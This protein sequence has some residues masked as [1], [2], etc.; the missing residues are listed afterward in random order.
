VT[1]L[2]ATV[3]EDDEDGF[4]AVEKARITDN[5]FDC[6]GFFPD[7]RSEAQLPA[8]VLKMREFP[9]PEGEL[10]AIKARYAAMSETDAAFAMLC[11]LGLMEDYDSLGEYSD[12][13]ADDAM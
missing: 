4:N 1:A 6:H 8:A 11:D 9:K 2:T 5:C 13:F 3:F 10:A 7:L 12:D